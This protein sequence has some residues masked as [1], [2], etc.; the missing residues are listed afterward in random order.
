LEELNRVFGVTLESIEVHINIYRSLQKRDS[1]KAQQILKEAME[2]NVI[3]MK[4][5]IKSKN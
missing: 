5:I 2:G 1:A 3:K 4:Q